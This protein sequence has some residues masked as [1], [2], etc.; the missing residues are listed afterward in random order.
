MKPKHSSLIAIFLVMTTVAL[1]VWYELG[2][3]KQAGERP[4]S[5]GIKPLSD[6]QVPEKSELDRMDR[7]GRK[8]HQL[9]T[10]PPNMK[11]QTDLSCIGYVP[12]LNALPNGDHNRLTD[13]PSSDYR[14]TLAFDGKIKRYCAIDGQLYAEGDQ[15]PDGA[16]IETIESRRVMITKDAL[17]QWLVVEPFF[18]TALSEN[19]P[20]GDNG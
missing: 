1:A 7:I 5:S 4:S 8:M 14:V 17:R 11:R 20:E 9:S 3:A 10:P 6:L 13:L 15:L 12:V 18:D 19:R 2:H 16:V